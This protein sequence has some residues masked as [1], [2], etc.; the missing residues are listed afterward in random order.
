MRCSVIPAVDAACSLREAGFQQDLVIFYT[1]ICK[2][3]SLCCS[4]GDS[5]PKISVLQHW[6]IRVVSPMVG[7]QLSSMT[8]QDTPSAQ[9]PQE[10][11]ISWLVEAPAG[12][13]WSFRAEGHWFQRE[14][15]CP[16][17]AALVPSPGQPVPHGEVWRSISSQS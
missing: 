4:G 2:V 3:D 11:G 9:T 16:S 10:Q 5:S 13:L 8:P 6:G 7:A 14:H 15:S 17:W 12:A 1:L